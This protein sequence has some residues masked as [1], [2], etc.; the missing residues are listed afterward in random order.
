MFIPISDIFC[1]YFPMNAPE[2]GHFLVTGKNSNINFLYFSQMAGI[3]EIATFFALMFFA[4]VSQTA[5]FIM[6]FLIVLSSAV[7]GFET[8]HLRFN[9]LSQVKYTGVGVSM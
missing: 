4:G 2:Y 8:F 7:F 3:A 1:P 5:W 6:I 9:N